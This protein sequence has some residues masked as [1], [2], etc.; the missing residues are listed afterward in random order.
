MLFS[1]L[2]TS[3]SE[4]LCWDANG[5]QVEVKNV[6]GFALTGI[7]EK[8]SLKCL[9]EFR[10]QLTKYGFRKTLS[11]SNAESY[12]HPRF[13]LADT[14]RSISI[15]PKNCCDECI[16]AGDMVETPFGRCLVRY[17]RII[18]SIVEVEPIGWSLS[19]GLPPRFFIRDDTL[20]LVRKFGGLDPL[21]EIDNSRAIEQLDLI[22]H[23]VLC[24]FMSPI[25]AAATVKV[26]L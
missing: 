12:H 23:R 16:E 4:V 2:S 6:T 21:S 19:N 5:I 10:R 11:L 14:E 15:Q 13:L 22:T 7:L 9:P 8:L 17:I 24:T 18:D 3:H 1:L 25:A 26:T 20:S